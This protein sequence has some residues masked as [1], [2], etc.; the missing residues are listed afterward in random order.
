MENCFQN[1]NECVEKMRFTP[2]NDVWLALTAAAS[3]EA[4]ADLLLLVGP[5]RHFS[6][7]P[8]FGDRRGGDESKR[9]ENF[10]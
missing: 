7:V 8:W 1:Q 2:K 6:G 9:K 4:G 5:G 3:R 10:V